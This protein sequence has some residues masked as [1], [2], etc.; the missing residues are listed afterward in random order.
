MKTVVEKLFENADLH[1]D[2]LAVVFENEEVTYGQL[3]DAVIRLAGW[4]RLRGVAEGDRVVA[5][6]HYGKWFIAAYYA[7]HLC[8]AVIVPVEKALTQETLQAVVERMDARAAVSWLAPA[9][10][11]SLNYGEIEMELAGVEEQPYTFPGLDLTAN[12]MLTSGTTGTPK[13]AML[14]Q[15]NLAVNSMVRWHEF[16]NNENTMGITILPLNHVGSS[17]MW[18]TAVY[19]GGAYIFLDG[20]FRIRTFFDYI[21]RYHITAF[22]ISPSGIASIEQ[23]SGDKLYEYAEQIDYAYVHSALMQEPQRAFLQRVLPKSRLYY[24][25]G[26]S[27]NGTMSLLRFDREER[28][29][30]CSGRPCEGVEIR[31]VDDDLRELPRGRQGRVVVRSEMNFRGYWAMPELTASV[32]HG[33][34]FL[35]N[36]TGYLDEDGYLYILGRVDDVINIGGLKVYPSEIEKA[37]A[38]LEGVEECLC[39]DVPNALMG[40]A[41][42]LLVRLRADT[43]LTARDIR[44]ALVGKLDSY[45]VPASIDVVDEI[46]KTANGKPDRKFYRGKNQTF[47]KTPGSI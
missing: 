13:G 22:N 26:S 2:K 6:A 28:D 46:R 9:A 1:P 14:T 41:V 19:S 17:R 27:E 5:Q 4:F 43:L 42:K 31:I 25:Y 37:A 11:I 36:D 8:E 3:K 24:S 35:T 18:D 12:I 21:T 45:K 10:P 40:S 34:W 20:L 44:T 47:S 16:E 15:R 39:V 38:E 30:R 33:D 7:A 29:I 32:Y 23:L